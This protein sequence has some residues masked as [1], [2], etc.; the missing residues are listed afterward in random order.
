[1]WLEVINSRFILSQPRFHRLDEKRKFFNPEKKP[2]QVLLAEREQLDERGHGER[3][4]VPG[5]LRQP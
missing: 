3:E 4:P 1:M 2:Q 5:V